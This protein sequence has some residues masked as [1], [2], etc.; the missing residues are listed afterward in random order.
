MHLLTSLKELNSKEYNLDETA[1]FLH[2]DPLLFKIYTSMVRN[3]S[4]FSDVFLD[5]IFDELEEIVKNKKDINFSKDKVSVAESKKLIYSLKTIVKNS[6]IKISS[7]SD[8]TRVS[9]KRI[10]IIKDVCT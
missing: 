5:N 6:E 3:D 2:V 8:Q 7:Y 4:T 9:Q 10:R 1:K